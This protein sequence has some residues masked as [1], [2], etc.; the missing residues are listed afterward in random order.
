AYALALVWG[1]DAAA[2]GSNSVFCNEVKVWFAHPRQI[3]PY[4]RIQKLESTVKTLDTMEGRGC[5][6]WV[7]ERAR[8]EYG[9][10]LEAYSLTFPAD[11]Q[12]LRSW[13]RKAADAYQSYIDWFLG[14]DQERQD[15]LIQSDS[16]RSRSSSRFSEYRVR[17]IL[18]RVGNAVVSL[19]A[20]FV[21]VRDQSNLL[22]QYE[23]LGT[24]AVEVFPEEAV[25]E[26]HKWLCALPD[27]KARRTPREIAKVTEE[28]P[29]SADHWSDFQDFLE[30]YLQLNPSV[31]NRWIP[32]KRR[33]SQW[34]AP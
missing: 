29:E 20:S 9:R 11:S 25:K 6:D 28:D 3:E 12:A 32:I 30:R 8:W 10:D 14:L 27:F 4:A 18:S 16:Q 21:R 23:R 24:S 33:I 7:V 31:R 17:W 19:G 2:A 34:L 26:W 13:S 1:V 22:V 5:E 15:R